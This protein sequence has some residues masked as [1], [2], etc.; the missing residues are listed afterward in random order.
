MEIST[1]SDVSRQTKRDSIG[2]RP[3]YRGFQ[4]TTNT[5]YNLLLPR[6]SPG[7]RSVGCYND[8]VIFLEILLTLLLL[9]VCS[10]SPGYF[11]IRRLPWSGLEKLCGSIALSL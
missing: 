1:T 2:Q 4:P 8:P 10:F 7:S 3:R 6:A 11:F 9:V 5:Q